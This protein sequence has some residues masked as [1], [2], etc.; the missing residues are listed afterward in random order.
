MTDNPRLLFIIR[1][2]PRSGKT[3]LAKTLTA[4]NGVMYAA[5]DLFEITGKYIFNPS[6]L[7]EAHETCRNNVESAMK[8]KSTPI[9]VHNTF[10][11]RWEAEPYFALAKKYD[12]SV[13]VTECQSSFGENGHNVP[14]SS[15]VKMVDRW[16]PLI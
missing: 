13:F 9:A 10:S 6:L 15:I 3:T 14:E 8:L 7:P 12:Y 5:D 1:G 11:Q 16:E 2:L 4:G